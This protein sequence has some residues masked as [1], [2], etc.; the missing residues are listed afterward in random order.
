MSQNTRNRINSAARLGLG[1]I[2]LGGK[3]AGKKI[4]TGAD[5]AYGKL[6]GRDKRREVEKAR[7]IRLSNE[8]NEI[9][10]QRDEEK[11]AREELEE[12]VEHEADM[13]FVRRNRI[14]AVIGML[15][16]AC[17]CFSSLFVLASGGFGNAVARIGNKAVAL[18]ATQTP[19]IVTSTPSLT[20]TATVT[21]IPTATETNTPTSTSTMQ[22]TI[23]KPVL[24]ILDDLHDFDLRGYR[25]RPGRYAAWDAGN[26][27]FVLTQESDLGCR[28]F[29]GTYE[30]FPQW[31]QATLY[32]SGIIANTTDLR[33]YNPDCQFSIP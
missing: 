2:I 32:S 18:V 15:L 23:G 11:K 4:A 24:I 17:I 19:W 21:A 8:R 28:T 20:A 22:P 12:K 16:L 13:R 14:L 10:R 1:F 3:F 5:A 25:L 30:E 27:I 29:V 33:A 7:N 6:S 9:V 26:R 31:V